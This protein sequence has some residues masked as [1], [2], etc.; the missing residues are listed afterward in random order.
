MKNAIEYTNKAFFN[1]TCG[2]SLEESEDNWYIKTFNSLDVED[3]FQCGQNNPNQIA[4]NKIFKLNRQFALICS[5]FWSIY[6]C[7]IFMHKKLNYLFLTSST[8]HFAGLK[9]GMS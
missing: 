2:L 1:K 3:A 7:R 4:I 8:K 9:A 5:S 6:Y